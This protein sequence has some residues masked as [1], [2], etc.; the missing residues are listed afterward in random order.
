MRTEHLDKLE[1]S[2]VLH[3]LLNFGRNQTESCDCDSPGDVIRTLLERD[4]Y[5]ELV[6][7]GSFLALLVMIL[8][9]LALFL[10]A[11]VRPAPPYYW[12]SRRNW[13]LNP[14]SD[15]Y[16]MEVDVT[17]K[18]REP[19][20]RLL[21][22]TTKPECM[23]VGR[24]GAWATHKGFRVVRVTRIENGSMWSRFARLKR[25]MPRTEKQLLL[26]DKH[27]REQTETVLAMLEGVHT[28][29]EAERSVKHFL[30]SL[31]LDTS[32]NERLLFHGSPGAGARSPSGDI[33]FL[34]DDTSPAFAI[35]NA[36]FDGR[37]G[38]ASGMYGSGTYFA[39]MAS[40]ADQYAGRYNSP[41]TEGGSVGEQAQLFLSRVALGCPYLASQSLEQLRRPPCIEGHFDLNL[42]WNENVKLGTPWQQ[43]GLPL[44]ICQHCR[45]DSVIGGLKVDGRTRL[46]REYV[47]YDQVC[48]PEFCVYYE[49]TD[50]RGRRHSEWPQTQ[51]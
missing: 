2:R 17:H 48:Y 44:R 39:D 24:D 46:Y 14:F 15:S 19:V 8:I 37:L 31:H 30:A 35:R 26:M 47:V 40:K 3:A 22:L 28:E 36:G 27:W 4:A 38:A 9:F 16:C 29:R 6:L 20:Q 25:S 50:V 12:R 1:V 34:S 42:L 23:G 18:L 43:K 51:A 45:F 49:R 41:G 11:R 33:L 13:L 10:G 32:K 7:K 5:L 21:D